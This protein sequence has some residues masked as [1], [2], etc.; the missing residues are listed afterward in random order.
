MKKNPFKRDNQPVVV[1][2]NAIRYDTIRVTYPDG[3]SEVTSKQKALADARSLELDLVLIAENAKPPVCKL[4]E[5]NKY[6]Y[7]LRQKEKEAKKK[8]RETA[9]EIKEIRLRL[10]IDQH[11]LQTK[12]NQV[13]KFLS[14]NSKVTVTVQLRGR[15]NGKPH[16]A[17]ELLNTFA[18]MVGVKYESINSNGNKVTGKFE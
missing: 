12:A 14:K 5:L 7:S 10:N 8:Q 11:D 15:E 3:V 13:K 16:L 9:I 4:I 18:E 17:T 2:N 6:L 1:Y